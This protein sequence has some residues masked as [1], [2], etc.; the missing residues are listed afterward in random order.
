MPKEFSRTQRVA[1]FLK[2][3]LALLI[4]NEMKDPRVGM[5]NVTDVD[6]SRDLAVARVFITLVGAETEEQAR[7]C[8]EVLNGAAGFLRNQLAA[9]NTLPTTPR[10]SF[11]YDKSVL[12]GQQLSALIDKAVASD[13]KPPE[14]A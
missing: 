13:R 7:E 4:H 10:L 1:D 11:H 8:A 9:I 2:R 14:Q 5:V 6:V 12:H 3:E